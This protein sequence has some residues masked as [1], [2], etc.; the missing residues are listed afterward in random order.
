MSKYIIFLGLFLIF[1]S[2]IWAVES[3]CFTE[4]ADI[5]NT[6]SSPFFVTTDER[7]DLFFVSDSSLV[8]SKIKP[9][10]MRESFPYTLTSSLLTFPVTKVWL[11]TD[12]VR[13]TAI[14]I[15][16]LMAPSGFSITL[17]FGQELIKDT[18]DFI[19]EVTGGSALSIVEISKDGLN[20]VPVSSSQIPNYSFRYLR[21]TYPKWE[22]IQSS[23]FLNTIRFDK[24][25]LPTYLISPKASGKI[26][27]L[28]WWI[29]DDSLL[30]VLENQANQ[31]SQNI[32]VNIPVENP[33]SLTFSPLPTTGMD[34]DSDGVIDM[35]D[36]CSNTANPDQKDRNFDGRGDACTDDD[37]D[38]ITG[39]SD[40]CPTVVNPDQKDLNANG[41][42]DACEFDSD[43]DGIF[44][45]ADTSIRTPNP[46]QKD[47]DGDGIGDA[48]DNCKLFNPDQID[49]DKNGIGDVCT[50]REAYEK[51]N[52][53]DKDGILDIDD[54]CKKVSN[55]DQKDS[56]GDGIGDACDNCRSIK[57]SDQKDENKNGIWEMCED[58]DLD[59]VDGWRDNCP[60]IANP[61]QTDDNNNGIGNACEDADSDDI[62]DEKDNCPGVYNLDQKDTDSD[63]IG[64]LC[65]DTDNRLIESNRIVFMILFGSIALVFTGGIIY[66]IKKI[67]L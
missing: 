28:R 66:F 20:Y 9:S 6:G 64:N 57:N 49:F 36:N 7:D 35:R 42:G 34:S 30:Y 15:D 2:T 37:G 44:D 4:Y 32:A 51:A 41:I 53:S 38:G 13:T 43:S 16:P 21:V 26:Q 3:R 8:P 48:C 58:T 31:L 59:G 60:S 17:D 25:V 62:F 40:N 47:S 23:V 45:G 33:L 11:L 56:D 29:C 5:E 39:L 14:E 54:S 1:P 27:A 61:D 24:K 52:D 18:F 22:K 65:D 46:D 67:K 50:V 12:D 55:P 19:Y 63:G 10:I